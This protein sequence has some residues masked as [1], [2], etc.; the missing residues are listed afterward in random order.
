MSDV[1]IAQASAGGQATA[2]SGVGPQAAPAPVDV[3]GRRPPRVKVSVHRLDGGREE[4]ESDSLV[5]T[6]N[7]FPIYTPPDLDR[8]RWIPIRDIKYVVLGAVDDPNLEPDPGDKSTGRKAILRFRDGEWLS[9]YIEQGVPQDGEGIPLKVRLTELQRVIPAVAASPS[10]LEMQ[11]VD[12]WNAT[13]PGSATPRRR[14]SDILESA[15]SQGRDL[16]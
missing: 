6:A 10:L 15:A 3:D 16:N 5:L 8:A 13:P 9:A 1:E 12:M 7:G 2:P 4:G 14:R 11:F